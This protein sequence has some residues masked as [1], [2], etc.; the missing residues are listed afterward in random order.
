MEGHGQAAQ[1]NYGEMDYSIAGFNLFM[2]F[3]DNNKT[4][5]YNHPRPLRSKRIF[6]EEFIKVNV[7][8]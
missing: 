3:T 7:T 6:I 8:C 1:T 4:I 5:R 2:G